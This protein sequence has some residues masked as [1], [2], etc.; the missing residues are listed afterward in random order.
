MLNIL[1]EESY[2]LSHGSWEERW[3]VSVTPGGQ[4]RWTV[5]SDAGIT[6]LDSSFPLNLNQF[7]HFCVLY[8]G[9]SM[10][11][12]ADGELNAF[13]KQSGLMGQTTKSL[14]FGRKD[15]SISQYYLRGTLDEVR[16]YDTSLNPEE[17]RTLK[18]IWNVPTGVENPSNILVI[19]PNPS[20]GDFYIK[21]INNHILK[22]IYIVDISG[23][24]VN[25][26]SN[27]SGDD[28]HIA[29][30]NQT[31]G[32]FILTVQTENGIFHNRVIL[33]GHR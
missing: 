24:P 15:E 27:K 14:T 8:S 31:A 2:I 25:F 33:K 9:Y 23:R 22:N 5:N 4:L 7:Y 19:Y 3:K 29:V 12:Y 18:S 1:S 32:L 10:E 26:I 13:T 21:G 30:Y 17:I 11:I 16:V 20:A 6:D 28:M